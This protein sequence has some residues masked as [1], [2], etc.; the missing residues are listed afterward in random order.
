MPKGPPPD[1]RAPRL[2]QIFEDQYDSVYAY[3]ARRIG[4]DRAGD[5]AAEVFVVAWQRIEQLPAAH[6]KPWL[7]AT[8]RNVI[9]Q[10][11]KRH[12]RRQELETLNNQ[13]EQPL[14][15]QPDMAARV[16]EQERVRGALA[17]ISEADRELVTLVAWDGLSLAD[18]AEVLGCKA[19]T[20]RVRWMRARNRL[21][22]ILDVDDAPPT[23][24]GAATNPMTVT[25]LEVV[26]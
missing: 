7:I 14:A 16:A 22:Q 20:A 10:D 23:G 13:L 12:F 26:R 25:P 18:A 11:S 8:A 6:E 4:P 19:S 9:L 24:P 17:Q 15:I 1:R 5:V 3:A 2:K 21:A